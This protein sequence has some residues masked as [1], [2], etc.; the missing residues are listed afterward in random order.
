MQVQELTEFLSCETAVLD[1][2]DAEN[3][4][5]AIVANVPCSCE[6]ETVTQ[7]MHYL[8][9]HKT[10]AVGQ[11]FPGAVSDYR[12][13]WYTRA[14][15]EFWCH[16]DKSNREKLLELSVKFYKGTETAVVYPTNERAPTGV[17]DT[18][19]IAKDQPRRG[20]GPYGLTEVGDGTYVNP[21]GHFDAAGEPV[22][23]DLDD[24]DNRTAGVEK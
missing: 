3:L 4:A 17:R 6:A 18:V 2:E 7:V 14:P 1:P 10:E 24:D 21:N 9:N 22:V 16:L 19:R 12:A 8:Y 20:D 5:K 15:G 13:Q 23:I 11:L